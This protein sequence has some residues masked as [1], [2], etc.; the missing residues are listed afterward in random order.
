MNNR[1][2][3]LAL[4]VK[5]I[6]CQTS[7]GQGGC[8]KNDIETVKM[9]LWGTVLP[10]EK[11]PVSIRASTKSPQFYLHASLPARGLTKETSLLLFPGPSCPKTD[12]PKLKN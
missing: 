12:K 10:K 6:R 9:T 2:F 5:Q 4:F 7:A 11:G 8:R 3:N 1:S